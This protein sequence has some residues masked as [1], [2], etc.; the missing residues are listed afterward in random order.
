MHFATTSESAPEPEVAIVD[1]YARLLEEVGGAKLTPEL[2]QATV[3]AGNP[4]RVHEGKEDLSSLH[5]RLADFRRMLE[6]RGWETPANR[7]LLLESLSARLELQK[8]AATALKEAMRTEESEYTIPFANPRGPD[9]HPNGR[10]VMSLRSEALP[11]HPTEASVSVFDTQTRQMRNQ[12]RPRGY[13]GPIFLPGRPDVIFPVAGNGLVSVP[14]QDGVLD[15]A[16]AKTLLPTDGVSA[17]YLRDLKP[18]TTAGVYFG[19][20][21][22]VGVMR[23]DLNAGTR[24]HLPLPRDVNGNWDWGPVPGQN[25][26]FFVDTEGAAYRIVM[27]SYDR[28]GKFT[29]ENRDRFVRKKAFG[30]IRFSPDGKTLIATG[31][32]TNDE[33]Q[34]G[35][36]ADSSPLQKITAANGTTSFDGKILRV[37]PVTGSNR[38]LVITET[39]PAG[40]SRFELVDLDTKR[41]IRSFGIDRIVSGVPQLSDDAQ[42]LVFS[43]TSSGGNANV[44]NLGPRLQQ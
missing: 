19:P 37:L 20:K 7:R 18:T 22:D 11:T 3:K 15:F 33:V 21:Q 26:Y 41:T 10:W 27:A 12:P 9:L 25:R 2:I 16:A 40:G 29:V 32:N 5:R 30:P 35:P 36:V 24:E 28:D 44:L 39:R 38:I 23:I 8:E 31:E 17:E 1:T 6:K 14:F 43:T 4:F 13:G 34:V 42:T